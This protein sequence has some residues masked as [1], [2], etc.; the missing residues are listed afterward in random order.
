MVAND[1]MQSERATRR[2]A[3]RRCLPSH[4]SHTPIKYP[5]QINCCLYR[6]FVLEAASPIPGSDPGEETPR[7]DRLAA[8]YHASVYVE[9]YAPLPV[10]NSHQSL[11]GS[12]S[13]L[14]ASPWA[15]FKLNLWRCVLQMSRDKATLG[16]WAA[17]SAL[18]GAMLG[19]L[20]WQQVKKGVGGGG[21]KWV[22]SVG[23]V[24]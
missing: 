7:M 23:S 1:E 8:A 6:D 2:D 21:V 12:V 24:H 14:G 17:V 13:G 18:I 5:R 11:G 16:L 15:L 19:V 10:D 22:G 3:T 9:T 4:L 20:Y